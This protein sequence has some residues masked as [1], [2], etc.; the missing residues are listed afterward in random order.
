MEAVA[1]RNL[2]GATSL[3]H[4][5]SKRIT[6]HN[7]KQQKEASNCLHLISNED[8]NLLAGLDIFIE[9]KEMVF[10]GHT[11][12]EVIDALSGILAGFINIFRLRP[13]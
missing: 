12:G 10:R 1:R 6:I 11:R 7:I 3:F 4:R 13:I 9:V 2:I 5:D 8:Y